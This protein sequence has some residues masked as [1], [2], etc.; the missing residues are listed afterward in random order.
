MVK[1]ALAV[2]E[3]RYRLVEGR[4]KAGAVSPIAVVEAREEVQR[5]REAAIAA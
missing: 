3:E 2:A 4:S 1:R 5:R